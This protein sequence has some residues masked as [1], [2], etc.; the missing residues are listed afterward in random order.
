MVRHVEN[1]KRLYEREHQELEET[2]RMLQES[3]DSPLGSKN[4]QHLGLA[5][6]GGGSSGRVSVG[7]RHLGLAAGNSGRVSNRM[8][9]L[10]EDSYSSS[11]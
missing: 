3:A 4:L 6:G 1:L 10:L 5:V 7:R 2:R 9:K 8:G 11:V